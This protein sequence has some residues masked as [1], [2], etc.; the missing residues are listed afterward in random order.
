MGVVFT[1]MLIFLFAVIIIS[2]ICTIIKYI[3][4]GFGLMEM[5]KKKN[6]KYP[7]LSWIPYAKEYLRGKLAY[8][9][10]IGGIVF[11][12]V[13]IC[14]S[15]ISF[16][17][18]LILGFMSEYCN[19]IS[20]V[21]ILPYIFIIFLSIGYSVYY[22]ITIYKLYKQFSEKHVI[23]LIFTILTGGSL[24]PIF[25]FAIRNNKLQ[26]QPVIAKNNL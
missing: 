16:I 24:S 12:C 10:N 9:T 8:N 5:A 1:V 13:T 3:F 21:F 11:L 2:L 14:V 7:W 20:I 18:G 4:E 25:I 17:V 26:E 6:E 22:Y 15:I 19:N 23:M